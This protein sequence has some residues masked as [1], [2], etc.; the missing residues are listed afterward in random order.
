MSKENTYAKDFASIIIKGIKE[1]WDLA[2][3]VKMAEE[4]EGIS[5]LEE[6]HIM[7][8]LAS[9]LDSIHSTEELLQ[10][11]RDIITQIKSMPM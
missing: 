11:L 3:I 1:D 2:F 4:L 5:L 6:E 7:S 10:A 8:L 9:R